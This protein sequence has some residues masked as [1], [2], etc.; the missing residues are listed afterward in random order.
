MEVAS[1]NDWVSSRACQ[2]GFQQTQFRSR[3][4]PAKN[5]AKPYEGER[6]WRMNLD[7]LP[8][9]DCLRKD[10]IRPASQTEREHAL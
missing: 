3:K 8:G 5:H 7:M 2:R 6:R 1:P 10:W 4:R 9:T